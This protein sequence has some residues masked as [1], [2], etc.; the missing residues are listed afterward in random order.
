MKGKQVASDVVVR[1]LKVNAVTINRKNYASSSSQFA[2]NAPMSK[3][4][5]GLSERG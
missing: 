4:G 5:L 2:I 1:F 3:Y